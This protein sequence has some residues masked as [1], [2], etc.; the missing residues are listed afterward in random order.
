L[1]IFKKLIIP[2]ILLT[3]LLLFFYLDLDRSANW[4]KIAANYLHIKLW[5]YGNLKT[6]LILYFVI[7]AVSVACSIPIASFLTLVGAAVLGW[8]SLVPVILG[9]T[10]G[11]LIV[12]LAA[13][14]LLFDFLSHRVGPFFNDFSSGFQDSPF[15]WLVTLRLIPIAPFWVV[16]IIPAILGMKTVTYVGATFLGILPGSIIYVSVG[17]GFDLILMS[18]EV[19]NLAVF[20][21]I[22][23]FGPLTALSLMVLC[24]ILIKKKR[25]KSN[26]TEDQKTSSE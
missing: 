26:R 9:A 10:L 8:I 3:G 19:P 21:N 11:A 4:Q 25:Q 20:Y 5:V 22:Q 12:F 14:G 16:N 2:C 7:Y 17:K 1:L 18:G 13:R 24:V 23:V 6:S 15:L